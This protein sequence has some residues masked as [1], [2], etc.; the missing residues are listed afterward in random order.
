MELT[1][2]QQAILDGSRGETMAKIMQ[3][4]VMYGNTFGAT[5]MVPVT[6]KYGHIVTS[7]GI[8][9]VK[10]VFKSCPTF[11]IRSF[12]KLSVFDNSFLALSNV[13]ERFLISFILLFV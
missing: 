2:E 7:F 9:I 8:F 10:G 5:K 6:S 4:L 12:L 1:K 3:T 11:A 13:S